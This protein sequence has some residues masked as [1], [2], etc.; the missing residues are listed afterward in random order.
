M[1]HVET[2]AEVPDMLALYDK[3]KNT[4]PASSVIV[5]EGNRSYWFIIEKQSFFVTPRTIFD[6]LKEGRQWRLSK[7]GKEHSTNGFG[8]NRY[9]ESQS[10]FAICNGMTQQ[11]VSR[12]LAKGYTYADIE[13]GKHLKVVDHLG[14]RYKSKAA[15]AQAYG[16]SKFVF[17]KREK[18][19]WDLEKALTTP[20]R[21]S[22]Q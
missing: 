18:A 6:H 19:G 5:R 7:L 20:V 17:D 14:N 15:M 1:P 11:Q 4:A 13:Q 22:K 10:D 12:L 8:T 3:E 9:Y 2:L 16:I 21:D